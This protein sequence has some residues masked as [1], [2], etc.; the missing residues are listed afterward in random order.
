[1]RYLP[2]PPKDQ[3][4]LAR[5]MEALSDA[6]RLAIVAFLASVPAG[7]GDEPRCGDFTAFGSKQNL[8]YHLARLRESGVTHTRVVGT[9]RHISLRRE[10]LDARFPGLLESIIGAALQDGERVAMVHRAQ[11]EWRAAVEAE[12]TA[13]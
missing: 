11:A 2:H 7:D 1:M 8:S 6:T 9:S 3:I 10:D 13:A 12:S 4:E 5:V